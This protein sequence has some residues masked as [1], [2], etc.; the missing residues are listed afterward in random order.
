[1]HTTPCRSSAGARRSSLAGAVLVLVPLLLAGCGESSQAKA[2]AQV[3][4]ARGEIAAQ[5]ARLEGL[6]ISANLLPD[7]KASVEAI[8]R[9]VTKIKDAEPNLEPA[10]KAQVEAGTKNFQGEMGTI[11]EGLILAAK[12]SGS[13]AE[14]KAVGP[15]I[16]DALMQLAASY[17][18]AYA[19]LKC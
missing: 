19:S 17:K 4:S 9:S 14:L 16:K 12:S 2:R 18:Q 1:M 15:E 3:C 5:V 11:G 7:A 13:I 6:S 10:V 8:N